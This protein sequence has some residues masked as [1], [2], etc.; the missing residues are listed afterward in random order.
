VQG[1]IAGG[2]NSGSVGNDFIDFG[3][4]DQQQSKKAA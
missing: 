4:F 3:E 1:R 2:P